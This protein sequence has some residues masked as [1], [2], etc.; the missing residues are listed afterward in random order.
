[1]NLRP[2]LNAVLG[3]MLLVQGVALA[4]APLALPPAADTEQAATDTDTEAMPCHGTAPA[5]D[6]DSAPCACCDHACPDMAACAAGHLAAAPVFQLRFAPA[7]QPA[8]AAPERAVVN[9]S[10]PLRLRPP[11]ALHA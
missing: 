3:L 8:I 7:P 11:I 10:P 5:P 6:T 1:M 4:S 9:V 2:W